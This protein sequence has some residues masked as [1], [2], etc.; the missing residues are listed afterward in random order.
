MINFPF[1]EE[2]KETGKYNEMNAIPIWIKERFVSIAYIIIEQH[3]ADRMIPM[4]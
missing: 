1:I 2:M 3:N 4:I